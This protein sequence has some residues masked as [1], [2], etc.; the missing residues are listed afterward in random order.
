MQGFTD[1][2]LGPDLDPA[3]PEHPRNGGI[4]GL[5]IESLGIEV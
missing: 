2:T 3:I 4:D 5:T 1:T